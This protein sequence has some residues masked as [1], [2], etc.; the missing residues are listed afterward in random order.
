MIILR[1]PRS[2]KTIK[3]ITNAAKNKKK[4]INRPDS[5]PVFPNSKVD[6]KADGS[7]ATIPAIIIND[8]PLPTPLAVI[9]SPSHIKK[10]VA[11]VKVI[12]VDN[13][14]KI[15]GLSTAGPCELV[16]PSNPVAIPKACTA[17]KKTV[18]YLVY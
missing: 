16:I 5:A 17:A 13:L 6:T 1:C 15:P 14:K 18:P 7:S 9:C 12:T 4:S 3:V 11:P 8:I 10:I 2:I